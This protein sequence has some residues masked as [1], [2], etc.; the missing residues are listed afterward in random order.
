MATSCW[1]P[2]R[3]G[4]G[5]RPSWPGSWSA[6]WQAA[7]V[8]ACASAAGGSPGVPASLVRWCVEQALRTATA[9]PKGLPAIQ[10]DVASLVRPA[11]VHPESLLRL[12]AL[13][14]GEAVEDRVLGLVLD[15]HVEIPA[16]TAP[17]SLA[18][19]AAAVATAPRPGSP[20]ELATLAASLYSWHPRVER[21]AGRRWLDRLQALAEARLSIDIPDLT[22]ALGA[23]SGHQW[24]IVDCLG[25]PLLSAV[26]GVLA[27]A[28]PAWVPASTVFAQVR[29]PTTTE[30]CLAAL[31]AEGVNRPLDKLNAVDRLL[32][33]RHLAF[34]ELRRL[35]AAELEVGLRQLGRR[36]D[37]SRPV[38]LFAD[39]GFRL[40]ADGRTFVHGGGSTLERVV[41]LLD[42]QPL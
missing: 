22:E 11:W 19:A 35:V 24:V 14:L 33:E 32:H 12:E 39:H 36:L 9:M 6:F 40:A 31:A 38:L 1:R 20:E 25:L 37:P 16:Q 8:G 42:L 13:E 10:P 28:L 29:P 26:R 18:E 7:A 15:G 34:A 17:G 3:T 41:P 30:S 4:R 5:S 2:S 27:A 21:V 23:F